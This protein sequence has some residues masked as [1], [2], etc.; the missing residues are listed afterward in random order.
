MPDPKVTP[1]D[2]RRKRQLIDQL[3][4][5]KYGPMTLRALCVV[6]LDVR[7]LHA[8]EDTDLLRIPGIGV[9]SLKGIRKHLDD[10]FNEE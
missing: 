5:L 8:M 6:A 2:Q 7:K 3:S 4:S 1:A 10:Y 9:K